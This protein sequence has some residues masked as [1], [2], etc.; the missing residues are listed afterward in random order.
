MFAAQTICS[1]L[2]EF[3]TL[4]KDAANEARLAQRRH[5]LNEAV[6]SPLQLPEDAHAVPSEDLVHSNST[7]ASQAPTGKTGGTK[8]GGKA[9]RYEPF[10]VLR[11]IEKK[12]VMALMDIKTSQFDLLIS[13]TPLPIVYAMRLG[14]TRQ[15]SFFAFTPSP[16]FELT[17][18]HTHRSRHSDST[19]RSYE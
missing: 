7:L 13:G 15:F 14:K 12:D 17:L 9:G 1:P 18:L 16:H 10:E 11:A 4:E 3:G 6:N 8:G 19:S 2:P 5:L